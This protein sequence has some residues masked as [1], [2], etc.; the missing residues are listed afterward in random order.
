MVG[1]AA[2]PAR[3]PSVSLGVAAFPAD[4]KTCEDLL[5]VADARRGRHKAQ[6]KKARE[7]SHRTTRSGQEHQL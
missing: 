2:P 6:E 4:A 7:F 5:G 1:G 3:S